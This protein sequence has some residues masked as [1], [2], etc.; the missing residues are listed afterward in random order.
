MEDFTSTAKNATQISHIQQFFDNKCTIFYI[1]LNFSD[2]IF[3]KHTYNNIIIRMSISLLERYA[4]YESDV[5]VSLHL[6]IYA[7]IHKDVVAQSKV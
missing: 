4:I 7:L 6:N 5:D 3:H 1:S 2:L